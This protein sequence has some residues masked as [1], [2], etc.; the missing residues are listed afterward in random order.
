MKFF[1]NLLLFA[2]LI[3]LC[4][5]ST[6]AQNYPFW[7]NDSK[8]KY[9]EYPTAIASASGLVATVGFYEADFNVDDLY[10]NTFYTVPCLYCNQQEQIFVNWHQEGTNNVWAATISTNNGEFN[11]QVNVQS[12]PQVDITSKGDVYVSFSYKG[13]VIVE[14]AS[15]KRNTIFGNNTYDMAIVK[16]NANGDYEW[17]IAEGG[18][19]NDYITDLDYNETTKFLAIAGYVEGNRRLLLNNSMFIPAASAPSVLGANFNYGNAFA[20]LYKDN[21]GSPSFAWGEDLEVHSYSTD[22]VQDDNG[23]VFMSGIYQSNSSVVTIA[24]LQ[25]SGQYSDGG[26]TD[27]YFI[28]RFNHSDGTPVWSETYG[29]RHNELNIAPNQRLRYSSLAIKPQSSELF[30]AFVSTGGYGG[31]GTHFTEFGTYINAID[32]LNGAL[33]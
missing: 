23:H 5:Y 6:L 33:N 25:P 28:V 26:L 24:G 18:L 17:H 8:Q 12:T 7:L 2:G 14:D 19:S 29:G 27:D 32:A 3:L 15:G 9:S 1:L 13:M 31:S 22:I 11:N 21:G 30:H 10:Y 4:T 16:F 20:A